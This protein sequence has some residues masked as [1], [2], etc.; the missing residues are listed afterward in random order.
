MKP[1]SGP[2]IDALLKAEERGALSVA[3][4]LWYGGLMPGGQRNAATLGTYRS[5]IRLGLL[6][7]PENGVRI[8][9]T[10]EAALSAIHGMQRCNRSRA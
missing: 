9:T 4:S 3:V 2:Q 5:L 8:T 7:C 1:L 10:G 6:S